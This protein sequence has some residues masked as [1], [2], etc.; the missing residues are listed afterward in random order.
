MPTPR[1]RQETD[2]T[3]ILEWY[4]DLVA[5]SDEPDR[6]DPAAVLNRAV[7]VGHVAGAAAGLAETERVAAVLGD[8]QQWYAVRAYLFELG[9]DFAAAGEA[10]AAAAE[11]AN[12]VAERDHLVRRAAR[13]ARVRRLLVDDPPSRRLTSRSAALE[14]PSD[15]FGIALGVEGLETRDRHAAVLDDRR[16][17]SVQVAPAR[18]SLLEAVEPVL[19]L[20]DVGVWRS[21]VFGE[22]EGSTG[23][24][25]ATDLT[26]GCGRVG[27]AA[28]GPRRQR[29]VDRIV[30]E[31]QGL[32]VEAHEVDL[33]V[34]RGKA[35]AGEIS[36]RPHW[37]DGAQASDGPW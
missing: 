20:L 12:E 35:L 33:D 11:R 37:V 26:N 18:Q 32:T 27:N 24:E 13:V 9:G 14:G 3:Q 2:W 22:V 15:D 36:A 28:Q 25:D 1:H 16:D 19:P 23:T 8:R 29:G 10:Y 5:L 4:D 31:F 6:E 7:A 21:A 17:V 34:T 30:L